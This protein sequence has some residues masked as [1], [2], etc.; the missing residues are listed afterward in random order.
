MQSCRR[1]I[2][3]DLLCALQA[4]HLKRVVMEYRAGVMTAGDEG[5]QRTE[6]AL[7][8]LRGWTGE[9]PAQLAVGHLCCICAALP[10]SLP[11]LSLRWRLSTYLSLFGCLL[12][13]LCLFRY[14]CL[15]VQ[16]S[17]SESAWVSAWVSLSVS[18]R[19]SE[20]SSVHI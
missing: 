17:I 12:G 14:V 10:L 3:S 19:V 7:A 5:I 1:F 18:L 15:S 20:C 13:C 8:S 4:F 2:C 16:V 6:A 9:S 11:C